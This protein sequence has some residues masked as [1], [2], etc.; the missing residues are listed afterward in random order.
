MSVSFDPFSPVWRDDPYPKYREL[1]DCAPLHWSPEAK[2]WCVSRY[3]DVMAVLRSH[4]LFSSR[5]MMT[6]LMLGNAAPPRMKRI[7]LGR[8]C[9]VN[10]PSRWGSSGNGGGA[11]FD[12]T[13]MDR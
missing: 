2:V 11:G 8:S 13:F 1:R 5:A 4:D 6:Q 3:E 9:H 12:S 7:G 10:V